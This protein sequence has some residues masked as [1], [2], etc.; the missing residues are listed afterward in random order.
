MRTVIIRPWSSIVVVL[1]LAIAHAQDVKLPLRPDSTRFLV[2]G[3]T[4]TGGREQREIGARAEQ[5]RQK[6]RFDFA[7]LLGDNLYGSERPQ[8]YVHKFEEPYK[9]LLDAGVK[10]HASL[11]NHDDPNQRFYKLF[12][13]NGERYYTFRNNHVQFFALDSNYLDRKQLEWLEE[14]LRKSNADWKIAFFHHPLYSSGKHGSETDLRKLLEPLFIQ[15]GLDVVFAGHEHFYERIK[16]QK[17]IYHFTNG[18]AAKLRHGDIRNIGLTEKG[19]DTDYSFMIVEIDKSSF[20]FQAISRAG[21]TVDSGT[22]P[23]MLRETS[24][25]PG[26]PPPQPVSGSRPPAAP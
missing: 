10:F 23:R 24:L 2:L 13:M 16:P 15:Y 19:F 7:L 1:L 21:Q 4:G 3:D 14:E 6:V 25:K 22:I 17:G 26:P 12:N 8:D 9:P 20:H 5:Y 18:G 11:G